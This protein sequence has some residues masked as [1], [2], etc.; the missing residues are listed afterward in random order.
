MIKEKKFREDLYYRLNVIPI[1]LP[2]LKERKED[3][4]SLAKEF[5]KKYNHRLNKKI[6]GFSQ[7]VMDFFMDYS[8]PGNIRE[9]EN[10]VEYAVN[11]AEG[12][13]TIEDIPHKYSQL[14]KEAKESIKSKVENVELEMIKQSL[15]KHGWD[16]KGK[17]LAAEELGIGLR[18]LYRKLK[19]IE[20]CKMENTD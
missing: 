8:W 12:T 17:A 9:L 10:I 1:N 6:P 7:E 3:V 11:M 18:T 5:L 16:V 15:D 13:I 20:K 2:P 19:N 14:N 4:G